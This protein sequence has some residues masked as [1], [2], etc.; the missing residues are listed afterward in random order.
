MPEQQK[1][2]R[3]NPKWVRAEK[4]VR[5]SMGGDRVDVT[6]FGQTFQNCREQWNDPNMDPTK[7]DVLVEHRQYGWLRVWFYGEDIKPR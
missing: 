4:V 5:G 3:N 6:I 2:T 1:Y 7:G